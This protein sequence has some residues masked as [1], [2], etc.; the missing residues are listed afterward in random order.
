MST[1]ERT[2]GVRTFVI[3]DIRGYSRYTEECG[4]EAAA[5]LSKRF[6]AIVDDDV[7]AHDGE[8]VEVRGD[9]ALIAFTSARQ[10]IR[11]AVDLQ[12]QFQE[13]ASELDIPLRVG[14]GIDSGEAVQLEDGSFRGSALN[15]AARL[16]GRASGGEVIISDS[17]S[18]LAGRLG[19]LHYSDGGKVRLKNIAEPVHIYKVYSELD[20][21]PAN[22]WVVMF[23]GRER[24]GL[25]WRLALLV[26]LIAAATALGVV[27][28][29]AGEGAEPSGAATQ[30]PGQ[31]E[32]VARDL[33]SVVP[34]E[35]WRD[36][37]V[38]P[39]PS[40]RAD[41][42]AACVPPNGVPDRWEISRYPNGAALRAAYDAELGRR[43]DIRPATGRC[44]AFVWGGEYAWLHGPGK[45]GG[46][47]F[48]Y[49]D[50]NDAVIVWSHERLDQQ[51]H[52]DILVT[53]R[54]G[55]SDHA[56][57]TRWWRPWHHVIGKAG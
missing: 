11:A 7:S 18:R 49:F 33:S 3:A 5:A 23:L 46:H 41:E 30:L 26:T 9:E 17:T 53:A 12:A 21:R 50:G 43:A 35:I 32:V 20:A 47:V 6:A 37:H 2:S 45:P 24:R 14:I 52:R 57:L 25:S 34:A 10:A 55:G 8:L 29:T 38:Q 48:C 42:T 22:R 15:V 19:G 31:Q 54:E 36:C 13:V 27:Y 44:N 4:D 56:G 51:T 28:L 1:A 40:A 39:V 16:C